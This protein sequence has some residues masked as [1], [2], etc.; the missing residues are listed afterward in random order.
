[1]KESSDNYF[2]STVRI[3][4]QFSTPSAVILMRKSMSLC[5]SERHLKSDTTILTIFL[6]DIRYRKVM[7]L[8]YYKYT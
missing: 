1:M 5:Y 4:F 6:T 2:L 8:T 3:E 7:K